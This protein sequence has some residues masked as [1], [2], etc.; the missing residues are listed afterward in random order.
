MQHG[1][2]AARRRDRTAGRR[3]PAAMRRTRTMSW[4]APMTRCSRA[5]GSRPAALR[6]AAQAAL[7]TRRR[8]NWRAASR[9]ASN[10]SCIR[11]SPSPSIPTIRRPNGS[12][13]PICC[14]ASSRPTEWTRVE[15]G[16]KQRIAGAQ[17]FPARHLFRLPRAQRRDHPA[18]HDLRLE[19]LPPRDARLHRAARRLC[20]CL[21]HRS[22][23][24]RRRPLRRAGRQSACALGRLLHARQS[25]SRAPRFSGRL[26]RSRACSRSSIIRRNCSRR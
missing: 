20:Q 1:V 14:R 11:A 19:A 2:A 24:A 18:Q 23:A 13:R 17:S 12:F 25:R 9:P 22:R 26:P 5:D 6:G 10:P 21:R 16:L 15:A 4:R 3:G 8:K 7:R